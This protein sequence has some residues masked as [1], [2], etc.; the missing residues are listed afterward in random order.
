[1]CDKLQNGHPDRMLDYYLRLVKLHGA[2]KVIKF[3]LEVIREGR[4]RK[5]LNI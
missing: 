2:E 1:M 4:N 5:T 3:M